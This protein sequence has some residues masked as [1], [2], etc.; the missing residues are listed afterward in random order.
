M[1]G[2]YVSI[3]SVEEGSQTLSKART[4]R[5]GAQQPLVI[6]EEATVVECSLIKEETEEEAIDDVKVKEEAP[7]LDL[8]PGHVKSEYEEAASSWSRHMKG[9]D[10]GDTGGGAEAASDLAAPL[11]P[12]SSPSSES[13]T[14]DSDDWGETSK[15]E[16][17]KAR[18]RNVWA[19]AGKQPSVATASPRE[20]KHAGL[21]D[22]LIPYLRPSRSSQTLSR[23]ASPPEDPP[24]PSASRVRRGPSRSRSPRDRSRRGRSSSA[25]RRSQ[26]PG[27]KPRLP[28]S[29]LAECYHFALSLVPMLKALD[30]NRRE[31][32][33][34]RI[35]NLLQGIDR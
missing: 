33:K 20:Y 2:A 8:T 9:E 6:K 18:R 10:D 19:S 23:S 3:K 31:A 30:Y 28:E 14:D 32:A 5:R 1:D 16:L 21:L 34:V 15:V 26:G 35:I 27:A 7:R 22:F 24:Y 13:D 29:K 12:E 25:E 11:L 17:S 4:T